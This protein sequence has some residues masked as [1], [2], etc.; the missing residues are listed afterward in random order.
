MAPGRKRVDFGSSSLEERRTA[1]CESAASSLDG[2]IVATAMI[3]YDGHR[4]W[5][6]YL[7]VDP[8]R[9]RQG[10]GRAIMQEAERLL[11]EASCPKINLQIRASNQSVIEFYRSI[12]FAMDDVVSMGKRL[13]HDEPVQ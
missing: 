1:G 2:E 8:Q 10:I 7:G 13:E 4:G 11:R 6:Y 12:G 9:Q 3:G 5:I